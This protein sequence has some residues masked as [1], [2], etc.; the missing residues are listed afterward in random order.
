MRCA[1]RHLAHQQRVGFHLGNVG[2]VGTLDPADVGIVR[3][4]VDIDDRRE[5]IVNAEPPHLRETRGKDFALFIRREMVEF[6]RAGQRRETA[7]LLQPPHQA[8]LLIDEHHRSGRQRGD[9]GA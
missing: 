6:L 2:G 9:L 5:I 1:S 3:I 8:A 4:V 7:A